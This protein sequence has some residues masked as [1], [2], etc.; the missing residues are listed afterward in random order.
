MPP[1]ATVCLI[2]KDRNR[3]DRYESD[4]DKQARQWADELFREQGITS[5]QVTK[6]II[7]IF[8]YLHITYRIQMH[9]LDEN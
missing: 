6:V 8:L 7:D 4:V 5:K 9:R 3:D 1:N 2:V